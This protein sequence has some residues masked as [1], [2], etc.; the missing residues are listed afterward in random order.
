MINDVTGIK[1]FGA[2]FTEEVSLQL[3]INKKENP[4]E[5]CRI[6]DLYGKNGS[7]KST[8]SHA[9]NKIIDDQE[10]NIYSAQ[11]I[12]KTGTSITL[13]ESEKE[14]VYIFNEEYID[15][16]VRLKE[17][18]L[19]TVVMLGETGDLEDK[20]EE[21]RNKANDLYSKLDEK[22]KLCNRLKEDT[23]P[24]SPKYWLKEINKQLRGDNHWADR[25]FKIKG[26]GK[27]ATPV[28]DD[29]YKQFINRNPQEERDSLIVEFDKILSELNEARSG[30]K[31]I[32]CKVDQHIQFEFEESSFL[33][34]LAKKIEEPVL[35]DRE[36]FLLSLLDS[37][38][39]KHLHEIKDYFS[40]DNNKICPF[41][42]QDVDTLQKDVLFDS[43]EKILN[44]ASKEHELELQEFKRKEI[45]FD[46]APYYILGE[47][48]VNKC[49]DSLNDFNA[50]V[51]IIN[52]KIEEKIGNLYKPID[53]NQQNVVVKFTT[54]K[55]N[56]EALEQQRIDYN[57]RIDDIEPIKEKLREINSDIAFYDIRDA[58]NNFKKQS[59]VKNVEEE[60]Y[61]RLQSEYKVCDRAI[62]ELESKKKNVKIAMKTI[63]R[64]LGYIF[65]SE[66]RLLLEYQNNKYLLKSRGNSVPPAKISA[67]E[68]N[69]LALCY[70]FSELMQNK[71][72][73]KF[74]SEPA[75]FI[76][77]DPI[78]SFDIEN[79]VGSLSFLKYQLQNYMLGNNETKSL[80]MTHDIQAFFDI[81][82]FSKEIIDV[83]NDK[84]KNKPSYACLELFKEKVF[85]FDLAKRQEYTTSL[86]NVYDYALNGTESLE[87]VIGNVMRRVL[88]AFS[89]FTYRKSIDKVSTDKNI[90]NE[91]NDVIAPYFENLLYRLVLHGGSHMRES[92]QALNSV[93]FF[94]Y[95]SKEEK[96]RT[97]KDI[98][99]FIYCLNKRHVLEHL[100]YGEDNNE[101]GTI[102]ETIEKWKEELLNINPAD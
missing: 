60:A 72:P 32:E 84:W 95:I 35:T 27:T 59:Q 33:T 70:F 52:E 93:D 66:N 99:C 22:R 71:E 44:K 30:N 36:K 1:L 9:F 98:I 50:I 3:F 74:Y 23:D 15:R 29:T 39:Q 37:K 2:N 28:Y 82:K 46:F 62:R 78:S 5:K 79:R 13:S 14:R 53:L 51:R 48:I 97:A 16:K 38:T 63:N 42:L 10:D 91:I 18:G 47:T 96:Q 25:D 34:L 40:K 55:Q 4:T 77:D 56:L 6:C 49:K 24:E 90:L 75:F 43:I 57:N 21:E 45:V 89:A 64:W 73:S 58:Y 86:K 17:D 8:I 19:D 101:I 61:T 100:Q 65:F 68:R 92:I 7:G 12:D 80:I 20:L 54:L 11:L 26:Y 88:E 41:C 76:I 69:A 87:M 81:Q 31:K 102:E 85:L 94:D 67:G 83:C